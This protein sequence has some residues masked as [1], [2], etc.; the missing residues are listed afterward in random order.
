[1]NADDSAMPVDG[2][3][4][5]RRWGASTI[6]L[7]WLSAALVIVLLAL[8][9]FMVH[10]DLGAS[11]TF[12]LYQLHKSLGFLSLALLL[13]RFGAR[14]AERSPLAPP[15]MAAWERRLAG[16]AHLSLYALMLG[17]A[18]SGWLRVSS[19]IIP[20]PT[21]FF[22]LFVIPNLVGPDLAFSDG[23]AFLHTIVSRLLIALLILHIAAALKHHL[24]DR[25][26]V[27][28][29]MLPMP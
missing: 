25:D 19:A 10:G 8:G 24:V 16:L 1:M 6:A 21:R 23:M 12:D 26:D 18:L 4:P 27:L 5:P 17:A 9:W 28:V 11:T 3:H 14:L 20:I 22:D 15:L 7:H 29:R 13:L 2:E